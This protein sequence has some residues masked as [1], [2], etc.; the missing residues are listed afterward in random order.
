MSGKRKSK[1][2]SVEY[3]NFSLEIKDDGVHVTI[4]E[5]SEQDSAE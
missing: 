4:Q 2:L 1:F 5:A 3:I